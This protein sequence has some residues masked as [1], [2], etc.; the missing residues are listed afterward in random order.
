MEWKFEI[1]TEVYT[2]IDGQILAGTSNATLVLSCDIIAATQE[3][4]MNAE[5]EE[6][7]PERK[8]PSI[9]DQGLTI[10]L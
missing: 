10:K 3:H 6:F 2:G 7:C 9:N 1:I 8:W 5:V 4:T